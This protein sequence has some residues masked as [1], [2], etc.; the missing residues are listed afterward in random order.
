MK[1]VDINAYIPQV[2]PHI[3]RRD[4]NLFFMISS[5]PFVE[6]PREEVLLYDSI[7]GRRTVAEL[8]E[9]P[10]GHGTAHGRRGSHCERSVR[11]LL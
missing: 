3:L 7:D 9:T 4:L 8:E 1:R 5:R 10:R 6:L 2:R 11:P